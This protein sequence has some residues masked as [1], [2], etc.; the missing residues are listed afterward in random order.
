[1]KRL[2]TINGYIQLIDDKAD[3]QQGFQFG[4]LMYRIKDDS[5]SFFY[6]EDYLYDNVLF[7]AYI[8]TF[9]I[10]NVSYSK[11]TIGDVLDVIFRGNNSAIITGDMY[12]SEYDSNDDGIVDNSEKLGGYLP[13]ELPISLDVETAIHAEAEARIADVSTINSDI[14]NINS[15]I[16]IINNKIGDIDTIL[17]IING[18]G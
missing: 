17:D 10:D 5:I 6:Q 12:K 9:K 15:D 14:T 1:M 13:S 16:T 18:E 2:N 7:T 4:E 11:T 3:T 8:P